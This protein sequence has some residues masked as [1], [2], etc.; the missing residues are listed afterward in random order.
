MGAYKARQAPT[1]P[2]SPLLLITTFTSSYTSTLASPH[3]LQ[4]CYPN[5]P[6]VP[7]LSTVHHA[8]LHR[9]FHPCTSFYN[10]PSGTL[11]RLLTDAPGAGYM[12]EGRH[13][14]AG[15]GVR[16]LSPSPPPRN[17]PM[18]TSTLIQGE[19]PRHLAERQDWPR[20]QADQGFLV[21]C[22]TPVLPGNTSTVR[23]SQIC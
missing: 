14:R 5:S 10:I 1:R 23:N 8:Y 18:L 17:R 3:T 20:L 13:A 7:Q 6:S 19:G 15:P 9:T 12:Q 16:R 21:S 2:R 4:L 22:L 11:C